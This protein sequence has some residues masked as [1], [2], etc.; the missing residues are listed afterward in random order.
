MFLL[1][2]SQCVTRWSDFRR[3]GG[4]KLRSLEMVQVFPIFY[5]NGNA[6][7]LSVEAGIF[8]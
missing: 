8:R 5:Y 3:G 6:V 2:R 4:E 1:A 7:V